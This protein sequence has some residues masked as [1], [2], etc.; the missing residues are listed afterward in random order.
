MFSKKRA[1]I[2]E[3]ECRLQN[4]ISKTFFVLSRLCKYSDFYIFS[5]CEASTLSTENYEVALE[6]VNKELCDFNQVIVEIPSNTILE[7]ARFII[8]FFR[9]KFSRHRAIFD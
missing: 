7:I 9:R 6:L 8:V 2:A 1:P 4:K 3:Y 5:F